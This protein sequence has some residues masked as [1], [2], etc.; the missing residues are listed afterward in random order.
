MSSKKVVVV[1]GATGWQGGSVARALVKSGEYSVRGVTRDLHSE[2]AQRLVR[3]GVDL[4]NYDLNDRL[5]LLLSV[6]DSSLQN[7]IIFFIKLIFSL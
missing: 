7:S 4:M 5:V 2:K 3:D 6:V 1:F